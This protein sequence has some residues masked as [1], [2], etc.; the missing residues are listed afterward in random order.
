VVLPY[1]SQLFALEDLKTL[2]V[3]LVFACFDLLLISMLV[4]VTQFTLESLYE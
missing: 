4:F 3:L 2:L 1:L